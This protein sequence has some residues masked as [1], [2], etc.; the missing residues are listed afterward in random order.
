MATQSSLSIPF[1]IAR[2]QEQVRL[3]ELPPELLELI[4][5][6]KLDAEAGRRLKAY[7]VHLGGL[8]QLKSAP[9]S[10]ET[11]SILKPKEQYVH[12]CTPRHA[13]AIRQVSTSNSVH[14][15]HH[16]ANTIPSTDLNST[17][18][19]A[20]TLLSA[21]AQPNSTLELL[22]VMCDRATIKAVIADQIP[23]YPYPSQSPPPS[24]ITEHELTSALPYPHSAVQRAKRAS[25]L[26]LGKPACYRA[27]PEL[28]L[29]A[30]K[31]LFQ[32][33]TSQGHDLA[34][35]D[36][37][38]IVLLQNGLATEGGTGVK[39]GSGRQSEESLMASAIDA[40]LD[41]F[42]EDPYSAGLQTG[43]K[44]DAELLRMTDGPQGRLKD[45]E[46]TLFLASLLVQCT[47]GGRVQTEQLMNEW[48]N[49]IP[50]KW[51]RHCDV[52][53][54][55]ELGCAVVD[56][57]VVFGSASS[58]TASSKAAGGGFAK[59]ATTTLGAATAA[60]KRNWHEMFAAQRKR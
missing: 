53:A 17:S 7:D 48:Q 44:E 50:E 46:T 14:I 43:D 9:V 11:G 33:A 37:S 26:I 30:W 58:G 19:S 1:A 39:N 51:H 34:T 21:F 6:S 55:S 12:L 24:S 27:T 36:M 20:S 2:P 57:D 29:A 56:G 32:Y 38:E 13:W 16:T 59:P 52:G 3:L 25:F 45:R 28:L 22:P 10:S 49:I 54:L 4:E 31:A 35:A 23:Y 60:G 41:E 40:L 5:T 47:P 15:L 18:I 42:I 8:I